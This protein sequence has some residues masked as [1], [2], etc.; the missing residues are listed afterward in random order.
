MKNNKHIKLLLKQELMNSGK[1]KRVEFI[2]DA[3]LLSERF[4]LTFLERQLLDVKQKIDYLHSKNTF[5]IEWDEKKSMDKK[6]WKYTEEIKARQRQF[7]LLSYVLE[8]QGLSS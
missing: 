1:G 3:L 8:C 2:K 6:I 5:T 7:D 4:S